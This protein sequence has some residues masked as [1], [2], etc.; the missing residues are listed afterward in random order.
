MTGAKKKTDASSILGAARRAHDVPRPVE[1]QDHTPTQSQAAPSA[2]QPVAQA[3]AQAPETEKRVNVAIP[4][5]L[6]K[7]YK[8]RAVELDRTVQDLVT[9]ALTHHLADLA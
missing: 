6:H 3:N 5:S 1:S 9:E 7:A 8:L 2:T 4:A